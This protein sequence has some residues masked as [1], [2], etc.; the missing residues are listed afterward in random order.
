MKSSETPKIIKRLA[1]QVG[2][3]VYL[4]PKYG[5]AGQIVFKN[6]RKFYFKNTSLD[7]NGFGAV[8]IARDKSYAKLFMK[9]LG[10]KIPFG[11][12]FFSD[13]WCKVNGAKNDFRAAIKFANSLGYP[14]ILKP[15]ASN[16]GKDVFKIYN[17]VQLRKLLKEVFKKSNVALLEEY[18]SG[19]D[20]RLVVLKKEMMIAYE[21]LPLAVIGNGEDTIRK[22]IGVRNR[23]F[24]KTKQEVFVDIHDKRI[25]ERLRNFYKITLRR[26]PKMGEKI[27]LLDNA[28]LS[29]GGEAVDV[30]DTVHS[31]Y[32][33]LA[34][35]LAKDMNL[36]F[37]GVDFITKS[38]ITKPAKNK[39]VVFLEINASPGLLH[40]RATSS[41]AARRVDDL[42]RKILLFFK[43][44]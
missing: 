1:K 39:D 11:R 5:L 21:R 7:I 36:N 25:I 40:Y 20:Y 13:H 43:K 17:K 14:V 15:N 42:Y 9:R 28:N 31:T 12:N 3:Q 38:D 29:S 10:Y 8:E 2:C 41:E 4:E 22:I 35:K 34:I 23:E 18:L 6:G 33:R 19:H 30:T 32:R 27:V 24:K 16:Q 37:A 44:K 26:I